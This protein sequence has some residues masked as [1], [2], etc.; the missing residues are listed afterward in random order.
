MQTHLPRL[1][2]HVLQLTTNN[3]KQTEIVERESFIIEFVRL[4]RIPCSDNRKALYSLTQLVSY[5]LQVL[6]DL[7]MNEQLKEHFSRNSKLVT[8][9]LLCKTMILN[10]EQSSYGKIFAW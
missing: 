4:K 9:L 1:V 3:V 8:F 5:Y 2:W 10:A 7:T 6:E